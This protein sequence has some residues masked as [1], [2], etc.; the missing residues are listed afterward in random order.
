MHDSKEWYRLN[1]SLVDPPL[2]VLLELVGTAESSAHFA[3]SKG[4]YVLGEPKS[5]LLLSVLD[6]VRSVADVLYCQQ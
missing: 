1:L 2:G 3:V 5:N 4:I 6:G